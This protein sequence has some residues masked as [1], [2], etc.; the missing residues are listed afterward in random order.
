VEIL[1]KEEVQEMMPKRFIR[2]VFIL[3]SLTNVW[4]V[5]ADMGMI[6][7]YDVNVREDSQK[8]I[9][10]HN[11]DEEVL[12]LGTDLVSDRRTKILRFI[13]FLSA[14]KVSLAE[15]DPFESAFKLIKRHKLVFLSQSKTMGATSSGVPVE[16][17]FNARLGAHDVTVVKV[18]QIADFGK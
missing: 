8:A 4:P 13:P 15:R 7:T 2:G 17:R 11:L 3:L 10:L 1:L 9:I 14:P 5:H 16:M 12:N 18:N 6:H